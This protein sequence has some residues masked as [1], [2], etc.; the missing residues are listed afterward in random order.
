[1]AGNLVVTGHDTDFHATVELSAGSQ[2]LF[3][4]F[5]NFAINGSSLP[6]LLVDTPNPSAIDGGDQAFKAATTLGKPFVLADP[7]KATFDTLLNGLNTGTYSALVSASAE[8]CGGCDLSVTD[9][10][11]TAAHG[12]Q[13]QDFFNA[14]GG[15]FLNTG[16]FN[17]AEQAAMYS[18]LPT[19]TGETSI[20]TDTGFS[21]TP[22]GKALFPGLTDSPPPG[23][24]GDV[25]GNQTHN[26]FSSF[27]SSLTVD[28]ILTSGTNPP[29]DITLS[30]INCNI[31]GGTI[32]GG[33]GATS[34]PEPSTFVLLGTAVLGLSS[35]SSIKRLIRKDR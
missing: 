7:A 27:A 34:V 22:E 35:L 24:G 33:P 19:I 26:A 3:D 9:L 28:E 18:Y 20:A 25:N 32:S 4:A 8:S 5:T 17:K 30:C 14:G 23:A 31:G 6:Y 13:I 21:L 11:K 15:I 16:G 12:T 29:Q 10:Q 2:N 1:L